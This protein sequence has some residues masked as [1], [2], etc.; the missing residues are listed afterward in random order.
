MQ[1]DDYARNLPQNLLAVVCFVEEFGGGEELG[2]EVT[3]FDFD[4]VV[5][6]GIGVSKAHIN[7]YS[8]L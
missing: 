2:W 7:Q 4:F 3:I 6:E 8:N 1:V 5:G